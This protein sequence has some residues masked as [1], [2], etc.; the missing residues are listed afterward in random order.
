MTELLK[1]LKCERFFGTRCTSSRTTYDIGPA[2][3]SPV[4]RSTEI[5]HL[6]ICEHWRHYL[7][8]EQHA[9]DLNFLIQFP[10]LSLVV[11]LKLL[12][13]ILLQWTQNLVLILQS[14]L[15]L[16]YGCWL[17]RIQTNLPR[18]RQPT[19]GYTTAS[20]MWIKIIWKLFQPSSMLWL[21]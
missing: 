15:Q 13:C 5:Q 8:I 16:G 6:A 19:N 17:A 21:K 7:L 14:L 4:L 9:A 11:H 2:Y 1:K 18:Q 20:Y 10:A 12:H 3:T